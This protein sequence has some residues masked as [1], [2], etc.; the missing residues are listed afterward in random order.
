MTVVALRALA[1]KNG[2]KGYSRLNKADLI[3]LVSSSNSKTPV[4]KAPVSKKVTS[5][6]ELYE[7]F[8]H[9]NVLSNI[10]KTKRYLALP[11]T[12]TDDDL[13]AIASSFFTGSTL[14]EM[15]QK[16]R[17]LDAQSAKARVLPLTQFIK[18]ERSAI[19]GYDKMT[20]SELQ[21]VWYTE[22]NKHTRVGVRTPV[23]PANIDDIRVSIRKMTGD[24]GPYPW[25]LFKVQAKYIP[26]RRVAIKVPVRKPV[27]KPAPKR[28]ESQKSQLIAT[29]F[30]REMQGKSPLPKSAMKPQVECSGGFCRVI[31]K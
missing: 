9:H 6:I 27:R 16:I 29:N 21:S 14:E 30:W 18:D 8:K 28:K 13:D 23:P 22:M 7:D 2:H 15:R 31:R 11:S 26:R 20:K 12:Y 24:Q 17:E 1:K 25:K 19:D 5:K 10:Y 4:K 3:T